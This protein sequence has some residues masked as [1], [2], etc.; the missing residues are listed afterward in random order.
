[1]LK[2]IRNQINA[3]DFISPSGIISWKYIEELNNIQ[4]KMSMRLGNK[5]SKSHI[6]FNN[7]KMNV[8]LAVQ[9]LSK[10]TADALQLCLDIGIICMTFAA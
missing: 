7:K 9:V 1:M 10:S 2:L 4:K 6:R 8:K 3:R 5:L